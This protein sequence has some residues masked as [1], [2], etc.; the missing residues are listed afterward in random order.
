MN[1]ALRRDRGRSQA[2]ELA[3]DRAQPEDQNKVLS[4]N[5]DPQTTGSVSWES[6]ACVLLEERSQCHGE[7]LT[8]NP[9]SWTGLLLKP[10]SD[11]RLQENP[12]TGSDPRPGATPDRERPQTGSDPGPGATPGLVF[13]ILWTS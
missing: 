9:G 10:G 5:L 8:G 4:R 11:P 13:I 1:A 6:S 7:Q 12:Q 2:K 3:Q